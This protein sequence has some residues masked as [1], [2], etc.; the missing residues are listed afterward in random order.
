MS[1]FRIKPRFKYKSSLSLDELSDLIK[2]GLE[3]EE[4]VCEYQF[5]PGSLRI[6]IPEE[7]RHFWSPELTLSIEKDNEG[8]SVIIGRYGPSP[9]TWTLIVAG[10]AALGLLIFFIGIYGSARMSLGL[11]SSILWLLPVL[12]V[13][14]LALY[15]TAQ[16]GQKLGAEQMYQLHFFF[17]N[18]IGKRIKI[19]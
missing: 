7:D 19:S 6:R 15:I 11:S 14:M 3:D 18:V 17:Q 8:N 4:R 13:L 5:I 10:Y 2:K 1:S 16:F 9:G 12:G